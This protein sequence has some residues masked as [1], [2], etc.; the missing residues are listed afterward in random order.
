[1]FEDSLVESQGR[2]RTRSRWFAIISFAAQAA[3]L[4]LIILLPI[5]HP[6]ALPKQSL[7]RLLVA[8]PPPRAPAWVKT[9]RAALSSAPSPSALN[10]QA[11]RRIPREISTVTD[12][13]PAPDAS[14]RDLGNSGPGV[15]GALDITSA[16]PP[17]VVVHPA[18]APTHP[19]TVSSGVA[20]G[21]LLSSIRPSY[22]AIARQARIQGTVLLEATISRD[23]MIENLRVVDGPPMLRQ[24]A[25]DAVATAR[26]RPFLLNG[27][28][29]EVQTSIQV[30]FSLGGE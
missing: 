14:I 19:L 10:L 2:I 4:L 26:Y 15:I 13:A 8:P 18:P 20:A 6:Q 24:A 28:P 3:L 30:I 5:L 25:M 17:P 21:R 29:V 27:Q 12:N 22:P 9:N 7:E 16:P 23:G 1:M 11:T